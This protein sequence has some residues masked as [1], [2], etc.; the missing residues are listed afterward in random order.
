[1]G[2]ADFLRCAVCLGREI[3][4][5][6]MRDD[7]LPHLP[8]PQENTFCCGHETPQDFFLIFIQDAWLTDG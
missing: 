4:Y 8:H 2:S 5:L 6:M 3:S 1:M 7:S